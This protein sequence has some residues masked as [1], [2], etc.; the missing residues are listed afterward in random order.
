MIL[1]TELTQSKYCLKYVEAYVRGKLKCGLGSKNI[2]VVHTPLTVTEFPLLLVKN[3]MYLPQ[4]DSTIL[5]LFSTFPL[6]QK[7]DDPGLHQTYL[8]QEICS[9]QGPIS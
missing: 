3:V 4:S 9:C 1:T 6:W 7:E 8:S 5:P 2:S